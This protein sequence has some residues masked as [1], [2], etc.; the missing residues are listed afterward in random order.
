MG[1]SQSQP[2]SVSMSIG[3]VVT[4]QHDCLSASTRNEANRQRPTGQEREEWMTTVD[5]PDRFNPTQSNAS[6][7]PL[8]GVSQLGRPCLNYN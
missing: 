1:I 5:A 7:P 2:L 4:I 6:Q 3:S 8:S